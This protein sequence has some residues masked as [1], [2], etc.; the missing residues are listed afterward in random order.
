MMSRASLCGNHAL[1]PSSGVQLRCVFAAVS[2][3]RAYNHLQVND[4]HIV[5]VQ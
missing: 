5:S 4:W 3:L 1:L 2:P